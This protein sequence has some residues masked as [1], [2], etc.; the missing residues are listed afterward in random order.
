M[1]L[2]GRPATGPIR[3]TSGPRPFRPG[4][5]QLGTLGSLPVCGGGSPV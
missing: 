3:D 2:R 4:N 5:K 1:P